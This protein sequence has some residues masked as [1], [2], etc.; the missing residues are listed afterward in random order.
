MA[1]RTTDPD[2]T[3]RE[4]M[5]DLIWL[6]AV[7]GLVFFAVVVVIVAIRNA[8]QETSPPSADLGF[9]ATRHQWRI[10]T[11]A[12]P[13]WKIVPIA[14]SDSWLL[15]YRVDRGVNPDLR[16]GGKTYWKGR[17]PSLGEDIVVISPH[18][19]EWLRGS[20]GQQLLED[21]IGT[22]SSEAARQMRRLEN[23]TVEDVSF[24][25]RFSV[26]A[27]RPDQALTV[28]SPSNRQALLEFLNA[29]GKAP[30]VILS[31]NSVTLRFSEEVRDEASLVAI[32]K[33]GS[34]LSAPE[35]ARP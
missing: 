9:I 13:D 10:E 18:L 4:K 16:V 1:K 24:N 30:F 23:V 31:G 28:A 20:V 21:I 33:L 17:I 8:F 6:I 34:K 11:G 5:S 25:A 19:P 12:G 22:L 14:Q 29:T 27:T 15:E 26:A 3:R 35:H 2:A 32:I 7:A